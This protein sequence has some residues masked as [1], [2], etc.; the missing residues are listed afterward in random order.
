MM[1]KKC[2]KCGHE[3]QAS[4]ISPDYECPKCGAIYAKVESALEVKQMTKADPINNI[5]TKTKKTGPL[6]YGL[7]FGAIG[8]VSTFIWGI[9]SAT[10]SLSSS[11]TAALGYLAVP[12]LSLI[13]AVPLFIL[14]YCFY[15][16][17]GFIKSR[18]KKRLVN[19]TLALGASLFLLISFSF[20]LINGFTLAR[21]IDEIDNLKAGELKTFLAESNYRDNKYVLE[22]VVSRSDIDADLLH[23]IA[24]IDSP[25][26]HEKPSDFLYPLMER[27]KK[28]R[29]WVPR[30]DLAV[31]RVIALHP[32]VDVRTL[33]V[34][35]NSPNDYVLGDVAS[36]K[37]TPVDI[38]ARLHQK[39]GYL[40]EWGLSVNHNCPSQIL[41][42]L[43]LSRDEYTRSNV[44]RNDNV[45]LSDLERLA[46]DRVWH[47]KIAVL[48][49]K[50]CTKEMRE[51][52]KND[53]DERV[54]DTASYISWKDR[55]D[56]NNINHRTM[57]ELE[58]LELE[59][60]KNQ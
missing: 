21:V 24:T 3:R 17:V 6:L 39:G 16:I 23:K 41:H 47:V 32:N 2:L 33:S 31:M 36:N 56:E 29:E 60:T 11:S 13:V 9:W 54:R 58:R 34:L 1:G 46:N 57:R 10:R 7:I 5:N 50:K 15:Y 42:E 19:F 8:F 44:A 38:L 49:N 35:A 55:Y 22:A 20:W 12:V 28:K 37:N 40:I 26:L 27:S 53:P 51:S 30:S 25:E 48:S 43:S 52:L 14:G 4:D 59:K 18:E 45:N